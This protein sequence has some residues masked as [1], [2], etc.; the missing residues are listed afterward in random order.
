MYIA[1][2]IEARF[3]PK[4]NKEGPI[5]NGSHCWLWTASLNWQGYGKFGR[6]KKGEGWERAHRTAYHLLVGEIPD[7]LELDH[8]CRNRR[9]VNPSHLEA[10]THRV[11]ELRGIAPMAILAAKTHCPQGHPYDEANTYLYKATGKDFPARQCRICRQNRITEWN[12]KRNQLRQ[13]RPTPGT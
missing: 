7:G 10:V 13:E 4:V 9:C 11:N 1:K 2:S 12:L 3:W 6:G 8:L 5:W